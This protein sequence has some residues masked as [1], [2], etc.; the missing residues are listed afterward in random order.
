MHTLGAWALAWVRRGCAVFPCHL[1]KKPITPHGFLDATTDPAQIAAWWSQWPAASIG[2]ACGASG[3]LVLDID[4]DKDGLDTFADLCH[5]LPLPIEDRHTLTTLT[6]GGGMHVIWKA[7][8]GVTIRNSAGKLGKGLDI[9]GDGGYIIVPPSP[10]PSGNLY[11]FE[12][13]SAPI[14]APQVLVDLLMVPEPSPAPAPPAQYSAPTPYT[15]RLL[16]KSFER[17]AGASAGTRN[18]TLNRA[19]YYLFGLA[20]AGTVNETDVR[21]CLEAAALRAGLSTKET[22]A[23]LG[24]A[25]RAQL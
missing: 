23:T 20:K 7:P 3:L 1:T 15:D 19:A 22:S 5:S 17:V 13:K 18:D 14:Q 2:V 8:E 25:W 12:I 10:H 24:S 11:R 9:R 4:A 16:Q 6:G 21:A